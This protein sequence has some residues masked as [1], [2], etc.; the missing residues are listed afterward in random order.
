MPIESTQ[1]WKPCPFSPLDDR[2]KCNTP[3]PSQHNTT[4]TRPHPPVHANECLKPCYDIGPGQAMLRNLRCV[5]PW[6]T[7]SQGVTEVTVSTGFSKVNV[8]GHRANIILFGLFLCGV[9]TFHSPRSP[10]LRFFSPYSFLLYVF[11][12]YIAPLQF[13]RIGVNI[14]AFGRRLTLFSVIPLSR[15]SL[16]CPPFLRI[17]SWEKIALLSVKWT[18]QPASSARQSYIP[19]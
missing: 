6:L 15:F 13:C 7:G 18:R 16:K 5:L 2:T 3:R 1:S 17:S 4:T 10:I 8:C 19:L 14:T 11:S 9:A 12:S